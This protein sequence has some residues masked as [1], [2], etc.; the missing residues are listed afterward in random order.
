MDIARTAILSSITQ[1]A[2]GAQQKALEQEHFKLLK[3]Q[4]Q[5][6]PW[7][8]EK[9]H[10]APSLSQLSSEVSTF[11]EVW[12]FLSEAEAV[13]IEATSKNCHTALDA[14]ASL[15]EHLIAPRPAHAGAA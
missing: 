1:T 8:T 10:S 7:P 11:S 5:Q 4:Q 9:S 14:R 2:S 15:S 6:P 12:L 13:P 3:M